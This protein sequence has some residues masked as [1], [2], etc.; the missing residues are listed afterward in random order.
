MAAWADVPRAPVR[1]GLGEIRGLT[2]LSLAASGRN[3][4]VPLGCF[5]HIDARWR[6]HPGSV[7]RVFLPHAVLNLALQSSRSLPLPLALAPGLPCTEQFQDHCAKCAGTPLAYMIR[8]TDKAAP[9]H[10]Q[11]AI[12]VLARDHGGAQ[13]DGF[14]GGHQR[15]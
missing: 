11:V 14:V 7:R 8:R 9:D 15:F 13:R 12:V 1:L 5:Q 3:W 2:F 6:C 4:R 10:R